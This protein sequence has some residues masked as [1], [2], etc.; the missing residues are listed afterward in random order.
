M[1]ENMHTEMLVHVPLCTHKEPKT[2]L[3]VSSNASK[4]VDEVAKHSGVDVK[5]ADASL[6][7]LREESDGAYD[8]VVCEAVGEEA[9]AA[10]ISRVLKSDGL[11]ALGGID[12]EK[13]D[14]A[15]E[16]IAGVAKSFKIVM[17][18]RLVGDEHA[19]LASKEYHPTADINLQRADLT[20]GFSAYNSD[21][22]IGSFAMPT[23][24]RKRYLGIVKN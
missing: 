16:R 21:L 1:K 17:P 18:Y 5:V 2:V 20:D 4:L 12:L 13:T 23:Y 6:E 22:H 24:I 15:K 9:V 14:A 8:V 11:A 7:V 19:L 3:I 10:H